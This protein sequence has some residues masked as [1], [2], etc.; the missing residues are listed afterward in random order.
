MTEAAT[1][2]V[3]DPTA[4]R[5]VRPLVELLTLAAPTVAQMASYTF[6]G[7]IDTV[8]VSRYA[9]PTDVTP[10]TAAANGGMVAFSI[11]SLGMG[12]M[13]VVNTLVSQAFG[14]GDDRLCGR[15]LWQ[16]VW[17]AAAFGL[18]VMAIVPSVP[19]VFRW[20]GHEP[21]L[22]GLEA[23]YVRVLLLSAGLK[24]AATAGEQFLLGVNRPVTVG[25]ASFLA[26]AVNTL[27][28]WALILGHLGFAPHGVVGSAWAQNIG[29]TSELVMVGA[30]A[31]LPKLRH[32]FGTF[33]WRPRWDA[34]AALLR[35]GV[36]SGVQV[37]AEVLAWSAFSMWV[38]APFGTGAMAANVYV[39]RYMSV[40]FMPA[41]GVSVAVTALVARYIGRGE[42]AVA[43]ARANLGFVVTAIYMLACGLGLFVFRRQLIGVFTADP[44]V[45]ATGAALLVFAAVYQLFDA[46]YIVYNGGLRGAGDTLVPAVVL[47]TLCWTIT[48]GV[49]RLIADRRPAWG[50]VGPWVAAMVYGGTLSTFICTRFA[51]GRWRHMPLAAVQSQD[52]QP[53]MHT[54]SHR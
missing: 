5:P 1:I 17:F 38:M 9:G 26:V 19:A 54:D 14:R 4:D 44:K 15:F 25:V 39:F 33:D 48:V 3:P 40:S 7:F 42:P 13:F 10:T 24:L 52:D 31:A 11:V 12:V 27:F 41:F 51:R 23:A 37:T 53:Q 20:A 29:V 6:M 43:V 18:G 22:A 32:R 47:T 50:P 46:T 28:A 8:I 16:G 34:M 2:L 21:R 45:L 30:F 36:P 35:M 49:G